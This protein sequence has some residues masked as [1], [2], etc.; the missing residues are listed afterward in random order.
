MVFRRMDVLKQPGDGGFE[1]L[2]GRYAIEKAG[3]L[4]QGLRRNGVTIFESLRF[5]EY[6]CS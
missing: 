4:Q 3:A 1:S 5:V 6:A 2:G